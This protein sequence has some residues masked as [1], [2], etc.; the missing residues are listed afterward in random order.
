MCKIC[1]SQQSQNLIFLKCVCLYIKFLNITHFWRQ[2][3]ILKKKK[4]L[5]T[6]P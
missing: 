5:F 1:E 4:T 3:D 2:M 6:Q